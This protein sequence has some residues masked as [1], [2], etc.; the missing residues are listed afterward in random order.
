MGDSLGK[1]V[2]KFPDFAFA[3]WDCFLGLCF[4]LAALL[5]WDQI[6]ERNVLMSVGFG[7]IFLSMA[8]RNWRYVGMVRLMESEGGYKMRLRRKIRLAYPQFVFGCIW[9]VGCFMSFRYAA[10]SLRVTAPLVRWVLHY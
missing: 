9:S 8:R 7:L 5:N 3:Y 2:P 4:V 6:P 1:F 10:Q